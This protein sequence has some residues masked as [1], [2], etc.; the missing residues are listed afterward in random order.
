MTLCL[1]GSWPL[2]ET[3]LLLII[4][5]TNSE[6]CILKWHLQ[7]VV[8][9]IEQEV[10]SSYFIINNICL[11]PNR[12][13]RFDAKFRGVCLLIRRLIGYWNG[14]QAVIA[15]DIHY[16]DVIMCAMAHQITSLTIVYSNV[17]SGTDQRK[18]QISASLAFV[19]TGEFPAQIASNAENVSI[20]WR[21]HS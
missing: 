19:V 17:Y 4:I 3:I 1:F 20:W 9:Y 10:H 12:Y 14:P 2:R 13:E 8:S 5:W 6:K 21:H 18:H 11:F 16:S 7:N 15:L